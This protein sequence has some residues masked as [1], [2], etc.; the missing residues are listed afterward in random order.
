LPCFT[1]TR[2]KSIVWVELE[3]VYLFFML[4]FYFCYFFYFFKGFITFIQLNLEHLYFFNFSRYTKHRTLVHDW[5]SRNPSLF[6]YFKHQLKLLFSIFLFSL[7]DFD[8]I[9]LAT[10]YKELWVWGKTKIRNF[11]CMRF[12]FL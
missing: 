9:I 4:S 5:K 3:S 7:V 6:F 2:Q 1:A 11:T 8:I 12:N 10:W